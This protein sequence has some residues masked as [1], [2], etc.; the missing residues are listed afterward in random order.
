MTARFQLAAACVAGVLALAFGA[1]PLYTPVALA[2]G[3]SSDHGNSGGS[4]NG[5]GNSGSSDDHGNSGSAHGKSVSHGDAGSDWFSA[6]TGNSGSRGKSHGAPQAVVRQYAISTGQQQGTLASQLK[7]WNSLN[8]NLRA[9]LNNLD[10]PNSLPGKQ[11]AYICDQAVAQSAETSFEQAGGSLDN[12]PTA[13]T[14]Q[15]T[16][17]YQTAEAVLNA[18]GTTADQVLSAPDGTYTTDQVAAAQTVQDYQQAQALY[19]AYQSY[20]QAKDTADGAFRSASVSYGAS[21]SQSTLDALQAE[22]DDIVAVKF[23][24][25]SALCGGVASN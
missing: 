9:Y 20:Q 1:S 7:S 25:T 6:V 13:P 24:D 8:R 5:H 2:A 14:D 12:P 23:P 3:H 10:N 15:Q 4:S 19:D 21:T 18:L 22:V 11:V 16:A 17:D